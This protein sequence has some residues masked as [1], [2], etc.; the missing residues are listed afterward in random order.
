MKSG[1]NKSLS[2]VIALIVLVVLNIAAFLLPLP[3]TIT[4]WVGYCYSILAVLVLLGCTMFLFDAQN[5]QRMFLRFPLASIAWWYF[6]LQIA[7]SVWEISNIAVSYKMALI[8]NSCLAGLFALALLASKTAGEYIETKD[9]EIAQKVNY[10]KNVQLLLSSVKTN[11]ESLSDKIKA[12]AEDFRFSDPMSH[13]SLGAL[14]AEIES[15][16]SALKANIGDIEKAEKMIESISDLLKERNQRCRMLKSTPDEK[17]AAPKSGKNTALLVA[18]P[19]VL[20]AIA[21]AFCFYIAP[22]DTY[23]K[24]VALY[25]NEQYELAIAAFETLDG[26]KDSNAMIIACETAQKDEI[27]AQAQ[28]LFADKEYAAAIELF[29]SILEHK[30]S[31]QMIETVR[32]TELDDKYAL[33]ESFF[34]E[35]NYV[36]ALQL[37]TELD[38]YNDSAQKIEQIQNRLATDDVLYY[39][40]YNGQSI[41]WLMIGT[42]DNRMLLISQDCITDLPY[43]D[44]L[45][46]VSWNDSTLCAWL[47]GEFLSVFSDEQLADL[48]ETETEGV[49][50]KVFLLST[51][52]VQSIGRRTA[53]QCGHN[54]WLRTEG[55]AAEAKYVN[56][57]GTVVNSGDS[58][59]RA[60][61]VRP[62]IWIS[63]E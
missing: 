5:Q 19:T 43:N 3:H 21:L 2:V 29:E 44:E 37:Y 53:L 48:V 61:G 16:I 24:A 23:K 41:A 7:A 57:N 26:F 28:S 63:L 55:T 59:V 40:T 4:F 51:S 34:N 33:A 10:L 54:W 11:D 62:C 45:Q 13:S 14:E 35:H 25:E 56:E 38:G 60:N 49:V 32:Q 47:N 39:G 8:I 52:E 9:A 18:I 50:S 42:E 58:V 1:K 15:E 22:N 46:D 27:Y 12:L 20:A 31:A 30:D 6:C 36:E 17:P